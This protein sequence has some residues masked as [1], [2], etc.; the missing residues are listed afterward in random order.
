M[1]KKTHIGINKINN[2][3]K[4]YLSQ[5]DFTMAVK[6]KIENSYEKLR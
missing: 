2:A 1:K 5:A 4:A 6:I 3:Q